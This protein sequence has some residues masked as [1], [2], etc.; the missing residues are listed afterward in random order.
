[1]VMIPGIQHCHNLQRRK[2]TGIFFAI[3]LL[4]T[5][6][7][8]VFAGK[9]EKSN[10]EPLYQPLITADTELMTYGGTRLLRTDD[11]TPVLVGVG[12]AQPADNTS[13]AIAD[14]QRAAGI[15]ARIAVL[16]M[17]SAREISGSR[18][19][20]SRAGNNPL[21][22]FS[23]RSTVEIQGT[24]KRLPVV[25]SWRFD[26]N[27]WIYVA[28]GM[29]LRSGDQPATEN[30]PALE[31]LETAGSAVE[32]VGL[33]GEEPF[34]SIIR[35]YPL[36]FQQPEEVH[37]LQDGRQTILISTGTAKIS[38]NLISSEKIA[39]LRAIKTLL[40]HQQGVHLKRLKSLSDKEILQEHKNGDS[41]DY[42][43]LSEY[44]AVDEEKVAGNIR[45]LPVVARWQ[46]K[47]GKMLHVAIGVVK[48]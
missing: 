24:I 27:N 21:S 8:S 25:G 1:M 15:K 3:I 4:V 32:I 38:T 19:S 47:D 9:L 48:E 33:T 14:A 12:R 17:V 31:I 22:F 7:M 36:T 46:E 45:A 10:F 42:M 18:E 35:H 28:V 30:Q 26:N 39:R 2:T 6:S 13:P 20:H 44:F 16:E 34:V 11:G 41:D 29:I 40:G 37:L 23:Q 43:L 5:W